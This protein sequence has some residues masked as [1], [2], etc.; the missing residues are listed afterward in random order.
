MAHMMRFQSISKLSMIQQIELSSGDNTKETCTPATADDK[1]GAVV[2][3]LYQVIVKCLIINYY[4][5]T[6]WLPVG[7]ESCREGMKSGHAE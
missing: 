7:M 2:D 1:T 3:G 4:K 5:T 6:S